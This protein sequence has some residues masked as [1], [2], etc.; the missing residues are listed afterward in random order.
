MLRSTARALMALTILALACRAEAIVYVSTDFPT[1]VG[2][3]R[4]IAVGRVIALQPQWTDGRRAIETLVTLEVEQY[5]KGSLGPTVTVHVP[6]GQMGPYLS[7]MPGAPRFADGEEVILF[8][9]G[10]GPAIPHILALG[11][12]VFRIV[13]DPN[14]G[15]RT[16][17]PELLTPAGLSA[18]R[19]VRGDPA[20]R[21]APFDRFAADVQ[22]LVKS[23]RRADLELIRRPR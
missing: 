18:V 4:A 8:L 13:R 9:A 2:D 23:W 3:A 22:A 19:V 12:G 11:Q 1:L 10:D 20:R 7:L 6:G 17:V 5:L 14:S 21:P 15:A 16:V